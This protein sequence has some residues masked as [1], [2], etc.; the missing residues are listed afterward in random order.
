MPP[1][2]T[3]A[4]F[5]P[6]PFDRPAIP[7]Y[8]LL[9]LIGQ[10]SYGDVWLA[11][12]VTG[13]FRAVKIVWRDRFSDPQPY[14]REFK[15]LSE[16][17]A[18]SLLEARQ[19]A[20]LHVGQGDARKFFYYVMELAD[21]ATS[22]R[23]IDPERYVPHTLK[24][25]RARRGRLPASEA[26]ALGVELARAL[27]GLHAHGLVHRD[28]KPSN[29]I[30]VGGVPK[31]ADIG[32]VA[33]ASAA[34]TF[35]GTE[36]YVPP[37]GPGA[38]AADV[39][40]LGKLLYE[41]ATGLDRHDYPRLPSDFHAMSDRKEL[42]EFNEVL[43]RACESDARRRYTDA[44]ALL[45]DLLLLQAGRSVRR[46]RTA[47][48]SLARALRAAAVL[49]IIAAVAGAGVLIEQRRAAR[50]EDATAELMR[51]NIYAAKLGQ[52]Q[53]ALEQEDYGRARTL[54][55]EA[56]P[57][58]LRALEWSALSARSEGDESRVL[59]SGPPGFTSIVIAPDCGRIASLNSKGE[60]NLIDVGTAQAQRT[61][62]DI[63][64][65]AGFT[66]DGRWLAAQ[67]TKS[68]R[69]TLWSLDS[70]VTKS[71]GLFGSSAR[72]L[73]FRPDGRL[74]VFT[75][76]SNLAVCDAATGE[77][78]QQFPILAAAGAAP[79]VHWRSQLSRDGMRAIALFIQGSGTEARWRVLALDFAKNRVL[80]DGTPP[81]LP[82]SVGLLDS[83]RS[84][85]LCV[86]LDS[87]LLQLRD[88]MDAWIEVGTYAQKL[89]QTIE[90]P[91]VP[92]TLLFAGS[93]P[94]VYE[95][96]FG[97]TAVTRRWRGHGGR[98][99]SL[100]ASPDGQYL[101]TSATD[102]TVRRWPL[103]R[104]L[105]PAKLSYWGDDGDVLTLVSA[106][107][108]TRFLLPSSLT[109]TSVVSTVDWQVVAEWTGLRRPFAWVNNSVWALT[110][111]GRS[112]ARWNT[113]DAKKPVLAQTIDPS[114][115][116]VIELAALSPDGRLLATS[117]ENG[118][119]KIWSTATGHLQT[120][121]S[122]SKYGL[123]VICF[124]SD[125]SV[126]WTAD[127]GS[128]LYA[129]DTATGRTHIEIKLLERTPGLAISPDNQTL[130]LASEVGWLELRS[131]LT[132]ELRTRK[133]VSP[134]KATFAKF[135]ADGRRVLIGGSSGR[136]VVVSTVDGM[137]IVDLGVPATS[138]L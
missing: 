46:L 126:L 129:S 62:P 52:A 43:I 73:G 102:G 22:G 12:G 138:N 123:W 124:T 50:A 97:T 45:D 81:G 7:D 106:P 82:T 101:F 19:L 69:L 68:D 112:A 11:R 65:L 5:T 74:V 42:L 4:S 47:E 21:D 58:E 93:A 75:G 38:P 118:L 2:A 76:D 8:E 90:H 18:V 109:S 107:D 36:G 44:G 77:R 115:E 104:S 10:G 26:V 94:S 54:L 125:S 79:W 49:A 133:M 86:G 120:T 23:E 25:V 71:G 119:V 41:V 121:I 59:Y 51:R 100:I 128:N 103:S 13:V 134:G 87:R 29:V 98:I 1:D 130:A 92:Q 117:A 53:R 61:T 28:I 57:A 84:F 48:R 110:P 114:S 32:L 55:A 15:G 33:A 6:S 136:L 99:Q 91:S 37:E 132:G 108:R 20:L 3:P 63:A 34:L 85:L 17:A 113:D 31:L 96:S 137:P 9:R 40:S 24:E 105:A 39:F 88:G 16:F 122:T 56:G 67:Q 14:Q 78:F 111:N 27:G 131:A 64:R 83:D 72:F 80:W 60:M 35:V 135:T 89:F 127:N 95:T 66:P 70:D 30:I 116:N